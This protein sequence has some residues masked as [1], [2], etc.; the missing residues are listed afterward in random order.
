MRASKRLSAIILALLLCVALA[1]SAW[2][3]VIYTAQGNGY[4]TDRFGL[5]LNGTLTSNV[6]TNMRGSTGAQVASF[7]T[8]AGG[9]RVAVAQNTE[10]APDTVWIYN[11][12]GSGFTKPLKEITPSDH[13]IWNVRALAAQGKYLYTIGYEHAMVARYDMTGDK[14]TH[15]KTYQGLTNIVPP[16]I[17]YNKFRGE[18][19]VTYKGYVYG[20]FS[21]TPSGKYGPYNP[22][23]LV[24]FDADLNVVTSMDINGRN[25]DGS[26][27]GAYQLVGNKLYVAYIGGDQQTSGPTQNKVKGG[28]DS[29][30]EVV[31][32]D[33]MTAKVLVRNSDLMSLDQGDNEGE[34]QLFYDYYQDFWPYNFKSIA[35]TPTGDV[36]IGMNGWTDGKGGGSTAVIMTNLTDLEA[37]DFNKFRLMKNNYDDDYEFLSGG[38]YVG[39]SM[40]YD[41]GESCLYFCASKGNTDKYGHLYMYKNGALTDYDNIELGGSLNFMAMLLKP[42]ST[43]ISSGDVAVDSTTGMVTIA[44]ITISDDMAELSGKDDYSTL[45][46]GVDATKVI[47]PGQ[48]MIVSLNHAGAPAGESVTFTISNFE[49]ELVSGGSFKAFIKKRGAEKFDM[50]DAEYDANA[51]TLKFTI[52]PVEDYISEGKVIIGQLA[53][54]SNPDP[55]PEGGASGGGCNGGFALAALLPLIARRKGKK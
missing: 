17:E 53:A 2:A 28:T 14:Y 12:Y 43:P 19:L 13:P 45:V 16:V 50:F 39:P 22:S 32:L 54:K 36:Y 29:M 41:A 5:V 6:V 11:P 20:I 38:Q 25:M 8:A 9:A 27:S 21:S 40:G 51:K 24:K 42:Q 44:S 33:K 3:D 52:S 30:V 48:A 34:G 55:T 37:G 4:Y 35:V 31:D 49:S 15:D 23:K 10:T 7:R 47:F 1:A 26:T 46:N 18:G